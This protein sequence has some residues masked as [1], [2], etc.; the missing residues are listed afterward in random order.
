MNG[1]KEGLQNE[2]V[3]RTPV[4]RAGQQISERLQHTALEDPLFQAFADST[5]LQDLTSNIEMTNID[6]LFPAKHNANNNLKLAILEETIRQRKNGIK[7]YKKA[8]DKLVPSITQDLK[9]AV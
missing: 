2:G 5:D 8:Y 7:G 3:V 4:E 9:S 6:K 1:G